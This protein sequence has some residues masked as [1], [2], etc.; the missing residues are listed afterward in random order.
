MNEENKNINNDPIQPSTNPV[1]SVPSEPVQPSANAPVTNPTTTNT[2]QVDGS[3][4][5]KDGPRIQTTQNNIN[6]AAFNM[7]EKEKKVVEAKERP[8]GL[9]FILVL[10]SILLIIY[11]FFI[12]SVDSFI[13][14]LSIKST[15]KPIVT[16]QLRCKLT[17]R[18][19]NLT[20]NYERNFTF[21]DS[22]VTGYS[23]NTITK[24]SSKD[25]KE[26][27]ELYNEC[28]N[29]DMLV[30]SNQISG[31][32]ISCNMSSNTITKS[33]EVDLTAIDEKDFKAAYSESGG[34]LPVSVSQGE[35]VDN[36]Q[37]MM[38]AEKFTCS[39]VE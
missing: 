12:D 1:N 26:L 34:T 23:F 14:S 7:K 8:K 17:D 30:D 37:Q 31:V 21:K 29:L 22:R 4:I 35:N 28:E 13:K 39:K 10:F 2:S 33:E 24:G 27:T 36:V 15:E 11:V 9:T 18:T 19:S 32:E 6:T 16:G 3:S 20:I 38:Q 5:K 25:E